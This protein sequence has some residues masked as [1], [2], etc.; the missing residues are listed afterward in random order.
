M[1]ERVEVPVHA[2]INFAGIKCDKRPVGGN[3]THG[4]DYG[5]NLAVAAEPSAAIPE[6][7]RIDKMGN[8]KMVAWQNEDNFFRR[9]KP[10]DRFNV[11]GTIAPQPSDQKRTNAIVS[12]FVR[13]IV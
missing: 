11:L 12:A 7:L 1:L 9:C 6:C 4:H 13:L 8:L 2:G 5:H 3:R 10:C